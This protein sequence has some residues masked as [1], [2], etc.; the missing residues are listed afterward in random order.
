MRTVTSLFFK[1]KAGK[2]IEARKSSIDAC[3]DTEKYIVDSKDTWNA[4]LCCERSQ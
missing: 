2:A 3:N 4:L 1:S